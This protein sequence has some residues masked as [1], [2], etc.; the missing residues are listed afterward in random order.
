MK[1]KNEVGYAAN[2]PIPVD[3]ARNT[4]GKVGA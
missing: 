4:D 1:E 2:T 3:D